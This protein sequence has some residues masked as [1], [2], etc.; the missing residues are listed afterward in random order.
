MP[1]LAAGGGPAGAGCCWLPQPGRPVDWATG[2]TGGDGWEP[3]LRSLS[4]TGFITNLR[5]GA[6]E[7]YGPGDGMVGR[8]WVFCKYDV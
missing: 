1:R 5:D 4:L 6:D 2:V 7:I 3:P 8:A